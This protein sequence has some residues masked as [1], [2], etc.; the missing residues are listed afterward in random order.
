MVRSL[1]ILAR[2]LAS[3]MLKRTTSTVSV[4]PAT[5]HRPE[6]RINTAE[7]LRSIPN[8]RLVTGAVLVSSQTC[9]PFDAVANNDWY[10]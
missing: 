8:V 7:K 1:P 9:T 10:R 2:T 4:E 5:R 3:D 6:I